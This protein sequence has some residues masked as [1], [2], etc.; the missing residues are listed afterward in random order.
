MWSDG[1]AVSP[2]GAPE[3]TAPPLTAIAVGDDGTDTPMWARRLIGERA[4]VLTCAPAGAKSGLMPTWFL[5]VG[6]RRAPG[7]LDR[8]PDEVFDQR[9][10]AGGRV[11]EL[12]VV[13][14]V[15]PDGRERQCGL[16]RFRPIFL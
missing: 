12:G 15:S 3:P 1:A 4:S 10:Q 13:H 8:F 11:D 2:P 6:D 9:Q 7:Q 14:V 5:A 16:D